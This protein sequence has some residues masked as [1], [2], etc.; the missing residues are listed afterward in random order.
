MTDGRSP[1]SASFLQR[2]FVVK[3]PVAIQREPLSHTVRS[4]VCLHAPAHQTS[5]SKFP[6]VATAPG[7]AVSHRLS[8]T[9]SINRFKTNKQKKK[10][11]RDFAFKRERASPKH[12]L[13]QNLFMFCSKSTGGTIAIQRLVRKLAS[14][15]DQ[16]KF[17]K[18]AKR[19]AVLQISMAPKHAPHHRYK[20]RANVFC[21]LLF[22]K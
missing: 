11:P 15:C 17:M 16:V 22:K 1:S 14:L 12:V 3:R 5:R 19:S 6:H 18:C 20:P 7:S 9:A 8:R 21:H 10:S 2:T 13:S 4:R